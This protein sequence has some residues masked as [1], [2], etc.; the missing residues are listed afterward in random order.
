MLLHVC[1]T[2]AAAVDA[3]DDVTETWNRHQT[4]DV[5]THMCQQNASEESCSGAEQVQGNVGKQALAAQVDSAQREFSLC[6]SVKYV[7]LDSTKSFNVC[8]PK[9]TFK[10]FRLRPNGSTPRV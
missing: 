2:A 8:R 6:L 3:D 1:N 9:F 4:R 10:I 5:I 7:S